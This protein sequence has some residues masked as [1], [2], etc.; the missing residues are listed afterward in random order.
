MLSQPGDKAGVRGRCPS[1]GTRPGFAGRAQ[2][3]CGGSDG[4]AK[5]AGHLQHAQA[6]LWADRSCGSCL[7]KEKSLA[8]SSLWSV[9]TVERLFQD[10]KLEKELALDEKNFLKLGIFL[11][12]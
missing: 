10:R 6:L 1:L 7:G 2:G 11:E 8:L 12:L 9:V 4:F 3:W 5:S